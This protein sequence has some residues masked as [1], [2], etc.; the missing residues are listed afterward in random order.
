MTPLPEVDSFAQINTFLLAL[1]VG[2]GLSLL[3]D[4]FRF[5][6]LL[7]PPGAGWLF[8]EDLVY[9]SFSG[10]AAFCFLLWRCQGQIRFFALL[11][12]GL[13][14]ILCHI[15]LGRPIHKASKHLAFLLRRIARWLRR[16][17]FLPLGRGI[18]AFF[19]FLTQ[20]LV[21]TKKILKKVLLFLKK[22]LHW[23]SRVVYN[24]G[25]LEGLIPERFH[26]AEEGGREQHESHRPK[27][28]KEQSLD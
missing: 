3:Y 8:L 21:R 14:W 13:G 17:I 1:A 19:G 16:R 7:F 24:Q 5:F 6:R 12:L 10:V 9:W 11:G 18:S 25:G 23:P 4:F 22:H 2:A 26:T 28:K 27:K 20:G 15:T